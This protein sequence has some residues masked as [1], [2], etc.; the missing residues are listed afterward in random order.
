MSHYQYTQ[1]V[2]EFC[3]YC[4]LDEP[5]RITYGGSIMLGEV[6]FSLIHREEVD[7]E[8]M[9]IYCDF[10]E[11]LE[12]K[13]IEVYRALLEANL[14]LYNGSAPLFTVN[15]D[16]GRV[17]MTAHCRL[18]ELKAETLQEI[19]KKMGAQAMAWRAD[20]FLEAAA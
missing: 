9:F 6:G 18:D 2:K 14:L 1:L 15:G 12:G 16:T 4:G 17:T 20:P 10:G 13:E 8:L 7:P 11:V 19:L 3:E 5:E